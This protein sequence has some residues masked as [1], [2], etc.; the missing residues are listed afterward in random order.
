MTNV[1][2]AEGTEITTHQRVIDG[3]PPPRTIEGVAV[4]REACDGVMR[5]QYGDRGRGPVI[6]ECDVCGH[7]VGVA[8]RGQNVTPSLLVG[9]GVNDDDGYTRF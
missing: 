8:R 2:I 3:K 7:V 5:A 4:Y 6:V 9:A 1:R